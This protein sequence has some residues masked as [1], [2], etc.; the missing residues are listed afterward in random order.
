MRVV[1]SILVL[2]SALCIG[3]PALTPAIK[4]GN[5]L[6]SCQLDNYRKTDTQLTE[7]ERQERLQKTAQYRRLSGLP[8]VCPEVGR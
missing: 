4:A 7:A 1:L 8:E 5:Q 3:C 6:Y 2:A